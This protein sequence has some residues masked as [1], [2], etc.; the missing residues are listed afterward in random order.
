MSVHP[1]TAEDAL[2][3]LAGFSAIIDARSESEYALDR[4]PG[5]VNWPSLNDSER[6]TIGTLYKQVNPFEAKK[7]GAALVARNVAAHIERELLDQ[8]KSWEPLVYCWRGGNRSGAMATILGAIGFKVHL[9]Q[10][11]YK[12]YRHALLERLPQDARRLQYRVVCGPTGS[13]KT[14]LLHALQAQGAQ[15]LDLE[16]LARHRS[17]VLGLV[18]GQT[19]PSQ[20]D[21]ESQLWHRLREFDP[22]RP[23]YVEA[24]SKRVGNLTV[25]EALMDAMR[26]SDC[27]TLEMSLSD[28]VGLLMEDYRHFT[29]DV[30]FFCQRLDTLLA[31]RGH[32]TVNSWKQQAQS[33]DLPEVVQALLTTHYDPR[34]EESMTRNFS[35]YAGSR[36]WRVALHTQSGTDATD[37]H[38]VAAAILAQAQER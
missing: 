11:G 30:D 34:Y 35:A 15:V 2:P 22:A 7:R 37:V 18:P 28:R 38:A 32:D 31:L 19:Q 21:F 23:V 10:G 29:D 8:P 26:A 25:P 14:R 6:H 33:G 16:G 27:L 9:L 12:A 3:R 13:G 4:V 1:I 17:S 5:A 20:K 36:R 24:E